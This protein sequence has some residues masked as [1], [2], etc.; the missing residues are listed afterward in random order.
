MDQLT[1]RYQTVD[2]RTG[3][4]TRKERAAFSASI[5]ME[6]DLGVHL[7]KIAAKVGT[8]VEQFDPSDQ[9]DMT[10][11][12]H[13]LQQYAEMIRPWARAVSKRI[14]TDVSRKDERA[15]KKVGLEMSE[16]VRAEIR[17]LSQPG[18]G[19]NRVGWQKSTHR[20]A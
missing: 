7:R 16:G 2:K 11:L 4:E 10:A 18:G 5:K 12:E 8:L 15:W 17:R 14:L 9:S 6:K 3:R 19:R 20:A 1:L 13:M